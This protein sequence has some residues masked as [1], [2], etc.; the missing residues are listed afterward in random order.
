MCIF[1]KSKPT[2]ATKIQKKLE[3]IEAEQKA[4]NE[5]IDNIIARLDTILK[6]IQR[7]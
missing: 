5:H 7:N 2:S 6:K 3:E 4:H 1:N